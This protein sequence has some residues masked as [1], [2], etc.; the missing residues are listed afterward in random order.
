MTTRALKILLA[1]CAFATVVVSRQVALAHPPA[2]LTTEQEKGTIEEVRAF[3]KSV[4]EAIAA[5]DAAKL[6]AA[7][8][9]S[10]H[11][12][13]GS[14][15]VDGKDARIV[16]VLAGDPVIENAPVTDLEIRVPGGWTAIATGKSPI[17]SLADGKTYEFRWIAVYVRSGDSWQI[18]ASQATRLAEVKP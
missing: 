12:A 17:K 14:G 5:K 3:R 16:A 10:F 7:Y 2:Q 9:D 6:R 11:H 4:V 15:K 18:A 8:A 1:F 13:H